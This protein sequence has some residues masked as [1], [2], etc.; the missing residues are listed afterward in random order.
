MSRD[1]FNDQPI[2]IQCQ[3]T[4]N[5]TVCYI[6][7]HSSTYKTARII[8]QNGCRSNTL[9]FRYASQQCLQDVIV[10]L[11]KNYD[12]SP[13]IFIW[14]RG[15]SSG[16]NAN[17]RTKCFRV[18]E[19]PTNIYRYIFQ[20]YCSTPPWV[21]PMRILAQVFCH[22]K[23]YFEGGEM[24]GHRYFNDKAA[25][26][27]RRPYKCPLTLKALKCLYSA[28]VLLTITEVYRPTPWGTRLE[29]TKSYNCSFHVRKKQKQYSCKYRSIHF[30]DFFFIQR[31]CD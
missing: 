6:S 23:L 31:I 2:F 18:K 19:N 21:A 26:L 17:N 13:W 15:W 20:M 5:A 30:K 4:R 14:F 16:Y 22:S 3:S 8:P 10:H 25:V 29:F 12:L 28:N 11:F 1:Y 9:S 7:C 24:M 27:I